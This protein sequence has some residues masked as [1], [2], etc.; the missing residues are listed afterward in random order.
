M[1]VHERYLGRNLRCTSC[2]TEFLAAIPDDVEVVEPP[3]EIRDED[4]PQQKRRRWMPWLLLL[5]PVRR[6]S[7]GSV[8]TRA[9][10]S[11]ALSSREGGRW[12]R[13]RSEHGIR[14]SAFTLLSTRNRPPDWTKLRRARADRGRLSGP[15]GRGQ[16][17]RDC[18]GNRASGSRRPQRGARGAS[19]DHQ[20]AV[21]EPDR[22]GAKGVGSVE[23]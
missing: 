13:S 14:C 10:G 16:L 18:S 9:V 17:F 4:L 7:G 3:P 5:L 1:Q 8:R 2:R 21:G 11:P 19:S 6:S 22:V 15:G 20:R 23:R 12:A